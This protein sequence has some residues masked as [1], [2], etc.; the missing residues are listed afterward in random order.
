MMGEKAK[1][2]F[3]YYYAELREQLA[4]ECADREAVGEAQRELDQR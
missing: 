3:F 2:P 1:A 4:L